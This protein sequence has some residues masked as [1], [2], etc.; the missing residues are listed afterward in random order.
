LTPQAVFLSGRVPLD[1]SIILTF[2]PNLNLFSYPFSSKILLNN[3]NLINAG[4][5]GGLNR[6]DNPDQVIPDSPGTEHWLM[7]NP[8]ETDSG[9]WFGKTDMLSTLELKLGAGY[10]YERRGLLAFQWNEERPYQ[11]IFN[12]NASTPSIVDMVFNAAHDEVTLDIDCT[13]APGETLEIFFKDLG[14]D[15]S[16]ATASGWAIAEQ[17]IHTSGNTR[18]CWADAGRNNAVQPF[19]NRRKINSAFMRIFMVSRQDIDSDNDR[20]SNGREKFVY[21]TDPENP[22]TDGD[23]ISDGDE[24]DTSDTNP[25]ASD[26]DSDG[27]TDF[28]EIHV[29]HTD[30]NNPASNPTTMPHGWIDA[31]IGPPGVPGS[32]SYFDGTYTVKGAGTDIYGK[33]DKF[34]YL[35]QDLYGDCTVIARVSSQQNTNALAK[36]GIMV[37]ENLNANSKN[38][39]AFISAG[40][41]GNEKCYHQ[42]RTAA[43]GPTVRSGAYPASAAFPYWLKLVK[44]GNIYSSYKSA[45]GTTWIA[46]YTNRTVTA[47]DAVKIGL[48]VTSMNNTS[49]SSAV[50]DK[51]SIIR[52]L[53]APPVISP[54]GGYFQ[55]N[56]T[57]TMSASIPDSRI[58]YTINGEEP[59]E[60]SLLYSAP[61]IIDTNRTVKA[62]LFKAGYNPGPTASAMFNQPGLMVKYY[63]GTWTALPDFQTLAP[64]KVSMLP[65]IEY[66]DNYGHIMTSGLCDNVGVV[67]TGQINCPLS[68]AYRFYLSSGEGSAL[69]ID[70]IRLIYSSKLRSFAQTASPAISLAAGL[71]D[72]KVEYFE[73][74]GSGGLQLKWSYPGQTATIIP[75]DQFF[76]QDTDKDNIPDQ[77]EIYRFGNL[78]H[79]GNGDTDGDGVSDGEEL[80]LYLTD[81]ADP[82]SNPSGSINPKNISN[83]MEVTYC[84]KNNR[85]WKSVPD[86]NNL[87]HYGATSVNQINFAKTTA[88]FAT[89]GIASNVAAQFTGFIDIP[90]DG[91]YKFHLN[92]DDGANLHIDNKR[93]VDNNGLHT[94]RETYGFASLKSGMHEI[95]VDYQTNSANG[96]V[97]SYE[98]PGL[99]K[100]IIP[101]SALFHSPKYLQD[102]INTNDLDSDGVN[103][104]TASAGSNGSITP[105]TAVRLEYGANQSYTIASDA[106]YHISD[107]LVDSVSTG[108]VTSYQ[109]TNVKSAHTIVAN[110]ALDTYNVNFDLAG[111]GTRA[112]GGALSQTVNY[113]SGASE[114]SITANEGWIFTGWDKDFN[115]I[116]DNTSVTAQY[117]KITHTVRFVEGINGTLTANFALNGYTLTYTSEANGSITGTTPQTVNHGAN[118]IEITASPNDEYH[119]VSWSDGIKTA[120]R[121]DVNIMADKSVTAKFSP[122]IYILTFNAGANGSISGISPQTV[123]PGG[124]I[125]YGFEDLHLT[126]VA[127]QSS[128]FILPEGGYLKSL[129]IIGSASDRNEDLAIDEITYWRAPA[130]PSAVTAMPDFGYHFISWSDGVTTVS[131]IE[132]NVSASM[133][134]TANFTIDTH[135]VTFDLAGKGTRTGGGVLTQTVNH[136]SGASAPTV[137]A[138][139]GWT[140]TGW[141]KTFSSITT[142]TSVTAQY[143]MVT[144]TI[145]ASA[146][147]NGSITPK[148]TVT[149]NHGTNQSFTVAANANYHVSDVLV[150]A[151]SVGAGASYQFTNITAPHT[152]SANFAINTHEVT[153][154]LEGKGTRTGGGELSQTVN[155]ESGANAPTV[156][157]NAGWTFTGWD[158]TF[159]SITADAIITAQYSAATYNVTFI[160]GPSGTI[161]GAKNQTVNHGNSCEEVTAVPTTGYHFVNWTGNIESSV[162]PLIIDN[163]TSD[164]TITANFAID[165]PDIAIGAFWGMGYNDAD[166]EL[167]DVTDTPQC[168]PVL[169]LPSAVMDISAGDYHNLFI[170]RDGSLWSMGC[171]SDG[172]LGDGTTTSH[173][174]PSQIV[175]SGAIAISAG[176]YHSLFLMNDGSLWGMG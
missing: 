43:A 61:F 79:N 39:F 126:G 146:G 158:K 73:T 127:M 60:T 142:D 85:T 26:S 155:H 157:A 125:T 115:N 80:N 87:P 140:F 143:A 107:V 64:Y 150:D 122:D 172:Q 101:A 18:V 84:A 55:M 133:T 144:Y 28:Q 42:E 108:A 165:A 25:N 94:M 52:N 124:D 41:G 110:F 116:T 90:L 161:S 166:G 169:I 173:G 65:T 132:T 27:Y 117:S 24:V 62:K 162:N 134:V 130:L 29:Y 50:F 32:A 23:G 58:R 164:T 131:R 35:Y 45:D 137:T 33:S 10:W 148:G 66:P 145:S 14:P 6:L 57:I 4:A 76:S 3:T 54:D 77:W 56:R 46:M 175:S 68:G 31:D 38:T 12:V 44:T 74:T 113:G 147:P 40:T 136:E 20:I 114:P 111:Y 163:I 51:L 119:F 139:P 1:D 123:H 19:V 100:Q 16:L 118:G 95:K 167:G 36:A 49:A 153:F 8:A 141:D 152:I 109:F 151:V 83:Q 98:G 48:A 59:A 47:G 168:S 171:N 7:D 93:I 22:D 5:K 128:S 34:N 135:N 63:A 121:T 86:F 149:L 156:T 160:E 75:A 15:D 2:Q 70:G 154:N 176:G 89:S 112:D 102:M 92:S 17:D 129:R 159:D 99:P 170:K 174:S 69:Y 103:I 81:P 13:G 106:N 21:G 91:F 138:N 53:T 104:I 71:H 88:K 9:K 82:A 67:I 105:N 72:I 30:P 97:L 78:D 11:N 120:S 37:R 96:L